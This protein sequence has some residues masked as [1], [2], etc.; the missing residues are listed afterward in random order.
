MRGVI[1]EDRARRRVRGGDGDLD[2]EG[3]YDLNLNGPFSFDLCR[4]Q[5]A[6]PIKFHVAQS[7]PTTIRYVVS[8]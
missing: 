2:D 6:P 4:G 3:G 8:Q 7:P 5:C 1:S